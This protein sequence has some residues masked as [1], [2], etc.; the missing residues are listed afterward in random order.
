MLRVKHRLTNQ[1]GNVK[2]SNIDNLVRKRT[3]L[4]SAI[5]HC[6]QA[7]MAFI[8]SKPLCASA[9]GFQPLCASARATASNID[10][11]I[12]LSSIK[13]R[14]CYGSD[15][16]FYHQVASIGPATRQSI[17]N[18]HAWLIIGDYRSTLL[19]CYVWLCTR[20]T[21]THTHV[22]NV[23]PD[24]HIQPVSIAFVISTTNPLTVASNSIV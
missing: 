14:C 19:G 24:H 11:T 23:H 20:C 9:H 22:P 15:K 8:C 2:Q 3:K 21:T 10:A 4:S 18:Q 12:N 6:A 13:H 17:D 5:G 7:H 1:P 16:L